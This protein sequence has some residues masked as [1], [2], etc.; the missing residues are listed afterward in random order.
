MNIHDIY[1]YGQLFCFS[2]LDGETSR[3]DDFVGM[4]M[5]EPIT[6]RFHFD[7][8]VSLCIPLDKKIKFTAVTGDLLCGEDFIV[9]FKNRRT[10]V[11]KAPVKPRVTT[12][13]PSDNQLI[14]RVLK[15]VADF[16]GEFYLDT[17]EKDGYYYFAFSYGEKGEIA[18]DKELNSLKENRL[19][20][21]VDKPKPTEEK[22][23]KIFTKCLSI[24]KENVYSPEG[25]IKC[26]WTT[27]DRVPHRFMWIWDSVFHAFAFAEYDIEMAKDA[28]RAVLNMEREDGFIAHMMSPDG[29]LSEITQ[30]QVLA[31]GVWHLYQKSAD[32]SFLAECAPKI[33]KFLRWTIKNRDQNGNGLLEWFTEPDY[34]ECKCGESGLDNSPRFDFDIE[35]DAVDFS[36]WLCNDARYLSLIYRE[37][38][39]V[40][41]AEYFKS[42]YENVKSK[43]NEK[44]WC[45][46]DGLYYDTL[47]NGE[48]TRVATPA[49]FFP[50]LAGV[51]SQEQADKMVKVLLDEKR[52]WTKMPVPSMPK[53]SEFYDIDMWRGCSWLNLNYF[54]IIGLRRYGYFDVAEE[55]RKKTLDVVYEWYEKTGNVFEFYDADNK[56]CPFNLKRK[57]E[58]P[59]KPDYKKHVHSITDFNWSACFT[60]LL[61]LERYICY[62][63]V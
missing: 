21:F 62:E 61:I 20:Y 24:N 44:L 36:T 15:V 26:R 45:E 4:L 2:G 23:Q 27:P 3:R 58:Q 34:T 41:N 19:A 13:K 11:G 51:C 29:F 28:I 39:D 33:A 52:F 59:P 22:Y 8:T 7:T 1:S 25:K 6:I 49:S 38:G 48:F 54:I 35:M 32:K 50:M 10:V 40:E 60:V 12:E 18:S 55:L 16:G 42:V 5:E 37:L 31:W 43:M 53:D 14:G 47:F 17:E 57:G 46:E 9:A 63:H 56:V 30:P